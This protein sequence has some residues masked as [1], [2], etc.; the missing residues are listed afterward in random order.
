METVKVQY[1]KTHL[2]AL[3]HAV[4]RGE[5]VVIARGDRPVARLVSIDEDVRREL[6][7]VAYDVPEVFF[8]PLPDAELDAWEGIG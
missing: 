8:D 3:L 4:E 6:G 2:S 7:F 5:D 1:A